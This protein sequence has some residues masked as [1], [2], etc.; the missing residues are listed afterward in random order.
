[1]TLW[2]QIPFEVRPPLSLSI[3]HVVGTGLELLSM[4]YNCGPLSHLA[5][6]NSLSTSETES[7]DFDENFSFHSPPTTQSRVNQI[8]SPLSN[9]SLIH[10]GTS[11]LK[12]TAVRQ[13][14]ETSLH[15][16]SFQKVSQRWSLSHPLKN[17][18][19]VEFIQRQRI[20]QF[21]SHC[22]YS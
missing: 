11:C 12:L 20:E 2:T 5:P 15:V 9:H 19:H 6:I 16:L 8:S 3:P 1:M 22:C 7:V 14:R 10:Q 21:V 17:R 13:H 4:N 18:T